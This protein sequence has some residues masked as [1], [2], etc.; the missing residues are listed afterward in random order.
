MEKLDELI[1]KNKIT[2]ID[3]SR[4]LLEYISR[5]IDFIT[6]FQFD[7]ALSMLQRCDSILLSVTKQCV[8]IDTD[9]L[10]LVPH[11]YSLYFFQYDILSTRDYHNASIYLFKAIQI[12]KQKI[13]AGKP[14]QLILFNR[15]LCSLHLQ[16]YGIY[17]QMDNHELALIHAKEAFKKSEAILHNCTGICI[18]HLY[19]HR[20]L[21]N[22]VYNI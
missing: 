7:D 10:S 21:Y 1:S 19:R 6:S 9:I 20:N 11:T 8:Y 4:V 3:I 12:L 15:V 14:L 13:V 22:C 18:N 16:L 2:G 5:S 17:I